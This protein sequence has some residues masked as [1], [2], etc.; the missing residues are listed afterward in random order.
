MMLLIRVQIVQKRGS[1]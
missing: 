1:T